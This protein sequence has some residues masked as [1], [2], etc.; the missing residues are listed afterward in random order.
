MT[1]EFTLNVR[2]S[3]DLSEQVKQLLSGLAAS[4]AAAPAARKTRAGRKAAAEVKDEP[5]AASVPA[6][7][8]APDTAPEAKAEAE[9]GEEPS[10]DAK[11]DAEPATEEKAGKELTTVDIRAAF[12]RTRLRIEGADYDTRRKSDAELDALHR[13]LTGWFINLANA[14]GAKKPSELKDQAAIRTFIEHCDALEEN[15]DGELVEN[16]PF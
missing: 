7:D 10:P 1:N 4:T 2:V 11:P 8:T 16:L 13:R 3:I 14:L 9:T 12:D 15:T 5:D 6:P